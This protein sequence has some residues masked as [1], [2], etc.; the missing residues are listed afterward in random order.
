MYNHT[1]IPQFQMPFQASYPLYNQI[2]V[3]DIPASTQKDTV[4]DHFMKYGN[5]VDLKLGINKY[6]KKFAFISFD[7]PDAGL[8]FIFFFLYTNLKKLLI[9]V[10]L[11]MK[12]ASNTI[13]DDSLVRVDT[14]KNTKQYPLEANIYFRN[15]P[16]EI[17]NEQI[18]RFF[19]Q[20][21]KVVSLKLVVNANKSFLGY[22]YVQFESKESADKCLKREN[23][24]FY[25]KNQI[26]VSRFVPRGN[27]ENIKNNLYLK[28]LPEK[29]SVE[30]ISQKIEVY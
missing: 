12:N 22:G 2:Y 8:Y 18:S 27:R 26:A 24:L 28:N 5:I 14:I 9:L 13:I 23:D 16:S 15:I 11:A 10:E 1:L 3:G 25:E 4:F 30:E 21:G 20:F 17:N 29:M 6:A 19:A 7:H